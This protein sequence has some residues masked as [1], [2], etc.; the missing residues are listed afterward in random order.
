[1]SEDQN[2]WKDIAEQADDEHLLAQEGENVAEMDEASRDKLATLEKQIEFYKDQVARAHAEME[3]TRRRME[4]EVGK[5]RK[6]G[7]ERLVSDLVPVLDSLTRAMEGADG[8][9]PHVKSMRQGIELTLTLLHRLLEKN[10]VVKIDPASGELFDPAQHEA[11]SMRPEPGAKT[12]TILQVLQP[13]YA[14]NGRIIRAAM[15]IVAQ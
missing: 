4:M 2:K 15:V 7:V 8:D 6:F 5:A 12:N 1:M 9:D 11:M 13:G 10:G 3:N 14:L